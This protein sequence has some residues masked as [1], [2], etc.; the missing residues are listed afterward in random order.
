MSKIE[1]YHKEFFNEAALRAD[2]GGEWMLASIFEMFE[3]IASENGDVEVLDYTPH[4]SQ[5]SKI[6]GYHHDVETG[7]VTIAVADFRSNAE[8]Q[9]LNSGD[10]TTAFKRAETF[11]KNSFV[12]DLVSSME[13]S[14]AGFQ[15]AYLLMTEQSRI[16]RIRFILLSNA[17]LGTRLK[18]FANKKLG[19]ITLSYNVLDFGRYFNIVHS[20]TGNEP[21]EVNLKELGGNP[22]PFLAATRDE[23]DYEAYLLAIPGQMLAKIYSE[24]GARLLEQNVRT[25]LQARGKVNKG[26]QTTLKNEPEMFFA[27]NNGLTATASRVETV[28]GENGQNCISVIENL[29]IVNGGQT[30]A[31]ML[32][33]RD[34]DKTD[35]SNVFVQV[36]L[37]VINEEKIDDVV[38]RISRYAN[39]QNKVSEADFFSNHPFHVRIEEFSRRMNAPVKEGQF[40]QS[41]WFYERARGQYK[42]GQA[43]L[44]SAKRKEFILKYPRQQMFT[45]T[46]LAKYEIS[47]SGEP[48]IVSTGAQKNFILFAK[49]IAAIWKKSDTYNN[50]QWYKDA[51]AK[52]IIFREVDKMVMSSEW[53]QGGY[54]ANIV[55]YSIA[56]LA[57]YLKEEK[58]S[59]IDLSKVWVS[60]TMPQEL[61]NC[62]EIISEKISI[63]IQQTDVNVQNVTEWC[64]KQAC[65][66]GVRKSSIQLKPEFVDSICKS[67]DLIEEEK[68]DAQTIQETDNEVVLEIRLAELGDRWQDIQSF[69]LARGL[70]TPNEDMIITRV[71]KGNLPSSGQAKILARTLEKVKKEGLE[72]EY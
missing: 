10:I 56:W 63:K 62:F 71:I 67:A 18:G 2:S 70:L 23:K 66:E 37:S 24:F 21:V 9:K 49:K 8:L 36:K 65:W 41:K 29:Q 14:S 20:R 3:E 39:T 48:H 1:E 26:I 55:T 5:G 32:Y 57:T 19:N 45:K 6:D 35:L 40:A 69:A 51:V 4:R 27:Y 47:F 25:F 34:H 7:T 33:A 53:Y 54:K 72:I 50:E 31:S 68:G 61:R 22:I 60:Q 58:K 52:A 17:E 43:Y 12:P 64:K 46:D 30:T 38:P 59:E 16:S 42:D 13:E 44:T 28:T 11:V 15:V